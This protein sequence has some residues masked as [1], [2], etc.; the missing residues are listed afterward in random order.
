[1]DSKR[2]DVSVLLVLESCEGMVFSPSPES[3]LKRV[4]HV[5]ADECR[6]SFDGMQVR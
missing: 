6:V 2:N 5:D 3:A 4:F 1:M